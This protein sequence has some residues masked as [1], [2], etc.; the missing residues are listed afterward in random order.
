MNTHE[1]L[2]VGVAEPVTAPVDEIDFTPMLVHLYLRKDGKTEKTTFC[3]IHGI[4]AHALYHRQ[5][6]I[7]PRRYSRYEPLPDACEDCGASFC[8]ECRAVHNWRLRQL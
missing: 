5:N 7:P 1:E 6:G 8:P 2:E 3:G 4:N